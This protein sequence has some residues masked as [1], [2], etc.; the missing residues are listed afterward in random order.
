MGPR[1]G[2]AGSAQGSAPSCR[3]SATPSSSPRRRVW[4]QRPPNSALRDRYPRRAGRRPQAAQPGRGPTQLRDPGPHPLPP[5]RDRARPRRRGREPRQG[6]GHHSQPPDQGGG[7]RLLRRRGRRRKGVARRVRPSS[8]RSVRKGARSFIS[9]EPRG[10]A[11]KSA[12]MKGSWRSLSRIPRS[13]SPT[14]DSTNFSE[15]K[16]KAV[17]TELVRRFR[18]GQI[19]AIVAQA[20]ELALPAAEVARLEHW[21]PPPRHRVQRQQ[22]GLRGD[23]GRRAR[24]HDPPGS[25][26][27]GG[28][29]RS[30]RLSNTS[31]ARRFRPTSSH[32]CPSSQGVTSINTRRP[33]DPD[34][35]AILN[36]NPGLE[37]AKGHVESKQD[38]AGAS[39]AAPASP[40]EG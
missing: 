13:R 6:A 31:P 15:E 19:R 27:A 11:L 22:G 7:G 33:I 38:P 39:W 23:Q 21:S 20:D 10:R 35:D 32:P 40:A 37:P 8:R 1:A 9:R 25:G 30:R 29:G 5:R 17:M 26:R 14:I 34:P 3:C 18:P 28:S 2:P 16:A 4:S 12:G 36:P 24:R